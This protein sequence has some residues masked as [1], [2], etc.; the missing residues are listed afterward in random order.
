[1]RGILGLVDGVEDVAAGARG[2]RHVCQRFENGFDRRAAEAGHAENANVPGPVVQ[3]RV[4]GDDVGVLEACERVVFNSVER[5]DLEDNRTVGQRSLLRQKDAPARPARDLGEQAEVADALAR[6]R[7]AGMVAVGFQDPAV[8]VEH[9]PQRRRPLREAGKDVLLN[10]FLAG[11][12]A[13]AEF[14][15]DQLD[16][17]FGLV[18]QFGTLGKE[19]LGRRALAAAPAPAHFPRQVQPDPLGGAGADESALGG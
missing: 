8:A 12:L 15:V 6:T 16:G 10:A 11:G 7:K 19:H 18:A 2:E 14:L 9:H 17:R 4:E 3:S 1:M 13:Q 5:G